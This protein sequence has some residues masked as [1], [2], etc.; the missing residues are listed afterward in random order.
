MHGPIVSAGSTPWQ[1]RRRR[2]S[3]PRECPGLDRA[4]I[5]K[6]WPNSGQPGEARVT[7][8][9]MTTPVA[10]NTSQP[11]DRDGRPAALP[12]AAGDFV[13]YD[14]FIDNQLHT[15][16][17]QVRTV[18]IAVSLMTL[19]AGTL[20]FFLLAALCD[21]W[22]L[23]GG[24][25]TLGRWLA[26]GGLFGRRARLLLAQPA[27][28]LHSPHQSGLRGPRHRTQQA[29]A[30]KQPDQF[31]A[32]A[33]QAGGACPPRL[34]GDRATR[35]HRVGPGAGRGDD[36]PLE[37]HQDRLCLSWFWCW[38]PRF[39]KSARRKIRFRPSA[40]SCCPGPTSPRRL[41]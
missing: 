4:S 15:A 10:G 38:S 18:D 5:L 28:A 19:G 27:A 37:T 7:E 25:G 20:G 22:L 17:R 34:R 33:G 40:G 2:P 24:L 8:C 30:E 36:R 6:G 35:R 12:E 26:S 3:P 16:R 31:S 14:Q 39:T 32:V 23:P 41:G 21:H 13:A 29:D 1:G 11:G 9:G